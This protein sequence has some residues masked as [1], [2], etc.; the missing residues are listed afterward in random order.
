[1]AQ[2]LRP[3]EPGLPRSGWAPEEPPAEPSEARSRCDGC[4]QHPGYEVRL[5]AR[6]TCVAA[7]RG[8]RGV[9]AVLRGHLTDSPLP[10]RLHIHIVLPRRVSQSG[11]DAR[12][13]PFDRHSGDAADAP[14]GITTTLAIRSSRNVKRTATSR[15][16]ATSPVARQR[17]ISCVRARRS[18]STSLSSGSKCSIV[19]CSS[20]PAFRSTCRHAATPRK[21]S[22]GVT[23]STS[24]SSSR[25]IASKSPTRT[26]SM[27][28]RA[29]SNVTDPQARPCRGN[30]Q[31][32]PGETWNEAA[33]P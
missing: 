4:G 6:A 7:R 27:N 31:A 22:R 16:Y 15:S 23:V 20:P 19:N 21:V 24:G 11:G 3:Q 5:H 1:M 13:R 29:R 9:L 8:H 28:R 30:P 2:R 32:R 26:A 10:D 18:P 25:S 17:A 12:V 14:P 33:G